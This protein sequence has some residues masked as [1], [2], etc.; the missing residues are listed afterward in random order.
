[1]REQGFEGNPDLKHLFVR[2]APLCHLPESVFT[3]GHS[4]LLSDYVYIDKRGRIHTAKKGLITDGGSVPKA[5]WR[6]VSSPYR[7]LL[8]AYLIHDQYC[9]A[10]RDIPDKKMRKKFRKQADLLLKEMVL[11]IDESLT[12]IKIKR[13]TAT[14]IYLGVRLGAKY[15]EIKRGFSRKSK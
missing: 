4:I 15:D 5:F 7:L 13:G 2:T 14:R 3:G 6:R 12:N 9:Q 1:M 8:P 11:W 10:A